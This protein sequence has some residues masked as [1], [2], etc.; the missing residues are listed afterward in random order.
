MNSDYSGISVRRLLRL[1]LI[2]ALFATACGLPDS[3]GA[4]FG[5]LRALVAG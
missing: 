3:L 1:A 2:T 4:V 5:A